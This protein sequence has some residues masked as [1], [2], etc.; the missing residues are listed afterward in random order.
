MCVLRHHD[1]AQ[2]DDPI[3]PANPFQDLQKQVAT[4]RIA[5]QRP[6]VIAAEGE[7]VE[8]AGAVSAVKVPG[9]DW[10]LEEPNPV[11]L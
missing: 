5:Q 2:D 9:N 3:S 4:G 10:R 7:E 6:A 8:I 1:I 11:C